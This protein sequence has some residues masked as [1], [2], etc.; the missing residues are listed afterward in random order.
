MAGRH[1]AYRTLTQPDF[2]TGE[3]IDFLNDLNVVP[4]G[5]IE[6]PTP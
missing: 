1:N 2:R 5:G 6:P 4:R 3:I